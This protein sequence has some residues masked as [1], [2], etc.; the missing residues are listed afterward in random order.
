MRREG[1]F[2][3]GLALRRRM[4]GEA[5]ADQQIAAATEFT[6]PLQEWVTRVCF[7]ELWHRPGLDVRMRSII[8][9]AMLA[10]LNRPNQIKVHV[11][12]ALENGVAVEEIREI[13]LHAALYAGVPAAVESFLAAADVLSSSTG[14]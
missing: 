6:Q 10:A 2:A 7:G 8:T 13:L 3:K 4:F 14:E 5:G 12:G 11:R 1:D 9:L